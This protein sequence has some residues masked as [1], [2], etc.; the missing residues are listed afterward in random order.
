MKRWIALRASASERGA[1][2]CT[3]KSPA[4][5]AGAVA[6]S[7][8]TGSGGRSRV[9]SFCGFSPATAPLKRIG[10]LTESVGRRR[11]GLADHGVRC[12]LRRFGRTGKPRVGLAGSTATVGADT[13]RGAAVDGDGAGVGAAGGVDATGVESDGDKRA[14]GA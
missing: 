2:S 8:V 7:V 4:P 5:A 12:G 13:T 14:V 1:A 6:T 10:A 9:G 3:A 11:I